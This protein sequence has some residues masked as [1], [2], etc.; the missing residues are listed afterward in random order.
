MDKEGERFGLPTRSDQSF[1]FGSFNIRK[2]GAIEKKTEGAWKFFERILSRF[3]VCNVQEVQSDMSGI[4]SVVD[5][6]ERINRTATPEEQMAILV[7][8]KAMS[9]EHKRTLTIDEFATIVGRIAG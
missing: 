1:L 2:M 7:E 4:D 9:L 3:D 8:V 6:L 5:G